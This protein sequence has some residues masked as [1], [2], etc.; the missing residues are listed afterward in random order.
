[1]NDNGATGIASAIVLSSIILVAGAAVS[2]SMTDANLESEEYEQIVEETFN[3]ITNYI[4]IKDIVGK[5]YSIDGEK[6]IQKIAILVKPLLSI[7]FDLSDLII[8]L[9]NGKQMKILY[10]GDQTEYKRSNT[11]FD[12]PMRIDI[13]EESSLEN[14]FNTVVIID[15]DRSLVDY[16]TINDNTDMFYILIQLPN[17]FTMKKGDIMTITLIPTTGITRTITIKAPI[18]LQDIV[19]LI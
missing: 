14:S 6:R 10:N 9:N 16:N 7:D 19:S 13:N 3:E 4:Q 5:Y 15:K 12:N 8:K 17:E 2:I 11:L 18:P 1:M